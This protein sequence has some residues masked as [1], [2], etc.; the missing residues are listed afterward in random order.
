MRFIVLGPT[1]SPA[2]I[3][4]NMVVFGTHYLALKTGSHPFAIIL[5]LTITTKPQA[6]IM[7]GADI[8]VL[9]LHY[10]K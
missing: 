6:L 10:K 5:I 1:S 2:T 7:N 3:Y 8:D 9:V 4:K